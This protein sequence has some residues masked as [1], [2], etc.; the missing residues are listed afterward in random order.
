MEA[1]TH[2]AHIAATNARTHRIFKLLFSTLIGSTLLAGVIAAPAIVLNYC[3]YADAET[4]HRRWV[5]D[6]AEAWLF[7]AAANVV[8]SWYLAFLV[9]LVPSLVRGAIAAGWG[10][11][12]E[13]VKTRIELYDSVKDTV[14]PLLYAT[15]AWVSWI[16]IFDN[17]YAL[18][19]AAA[20]VTSE[21]A[22]TDRMAEVVE[23]GFFLA[24]V[25]CV[26]QMLSHAIGKPPPSVIIG[27]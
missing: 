10:H 9:D 5:K 24:L 18:H 23:F 14:K 27:C 21:A 4:P 26:Q 6:N 22:Y 3:W 17:I 15:S 19:N 20:D 2:P 12:S 13:R 11:V 1:R 25:I 8:V 16:V 7:W